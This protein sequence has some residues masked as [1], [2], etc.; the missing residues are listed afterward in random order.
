LRR[1]AGL[2]AAGLRAVA[3]LRAAVVRRVPVERVRDVDLVPLDLLLAVAMCLLLLGEFGGNNYTRKYGSCLGCHS[4]RTA[5]FLR[6]YALCPA[7]SAPLD[8]APLDA[9][10]SASMPTNFA[11]TGASLHSTP[12]LV[13]DV[14]ALPHGVCAPRPEWLAFLNMWGYVYIALD[15]DAASLPHALAWSDAL[16]SHRSHVVGLTWET[17]LRETITSGTTL[18]KL[19]QLPEAS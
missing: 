15:P 13:L 9:P 18:R 19:L 1:A 11:T 8:A 4:A 7:P 2:R 14:L 3:G 5:C 17:D 10:K 16:G 6:G 12:G